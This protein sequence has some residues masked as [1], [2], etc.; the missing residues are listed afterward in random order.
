MKTGV[1]AC[2]LERAVDDRALRV[3]KS[4]ASGRPAPIPFTT[5]I[6]AIVSSTSDAA[7]PPR[8]LQA[9]GVRW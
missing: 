1:E 3:R 8:L 5:R 6:P 2:D 9:L 4:P 7:A